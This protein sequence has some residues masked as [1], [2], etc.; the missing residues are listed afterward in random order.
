MYTLAIPNP[1]YSEE[2]KSEEPEYFLRPHSQQ[3]ICKLAEKWEVIIYSSRKAEQLASLVESLDPLKT[4]IKFVLDRRHC[5]ITSQ[6]KCIKDLATVQNVSLEN[7]IIIDYKP[8][9]VA[10]S[11]DNALIV[12]HWNGV[13]D[14]KELLPGLFD[15]LDYLSKQ[16]SLLESLHQAT[17]Y[18]ELLSQ[19]YKLP[20]TIN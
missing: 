20:T 8:Q 7:S 15:H 17:Q 5:S 4:A 9:N 13:E 18:Q 6:K 3:F 16:P 1:S 14:D 11:L 19:I 10:F 12:L 2:T